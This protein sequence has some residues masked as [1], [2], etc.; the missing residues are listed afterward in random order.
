MDEFFVGSQAL[1]LERPG[2]IGQLLRFPGI[3]L[4]VNDERRTLTVSKGIIER[5]ESKISIY[6]CLEE[7]GKRGWLVLYEEL[8]DER[9][10]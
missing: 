2:V 5:H 3:S 6:D 10:D 7:A 4:L 1:K 9:E 8:I